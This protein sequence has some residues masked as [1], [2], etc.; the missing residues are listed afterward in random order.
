M[1]ADLPVIRLVS[2]LATWIGLI[3]LI[4]LATLWWN[5]EQRDAAYWWLAV[6]F[7][8]S[9]LADMAALVIDPFTVSLVYPIS[10]TGLIAAVFLSK[11]GARILV[12]GLLGIGAVAAMIHEPGK[13]DFLLHACAWA[14][15]V[16]MVEDINALPTIRAALLI[17]FGL[18]LLAWAS[19]VI[20]PGWTSWLFFQSCRAV[21][22]GIFCYAAVHVRPALH[23]LRPSRKVA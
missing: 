22:L 18:G 1:P 2:E 11:R 20:I 9:W 6:A 12:L 17:Y 23:I 15:I 7:G 10:Q 8:V 21:G 5:G 4:C 19:Y 16:A 14:M 13:P 3:P